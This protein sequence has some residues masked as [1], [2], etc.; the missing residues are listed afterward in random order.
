VKA[1]KEFKEE[2]KSKID[3]IDEYLSQQFQ[4]IEM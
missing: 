4:F 3:F 1:I 2:E